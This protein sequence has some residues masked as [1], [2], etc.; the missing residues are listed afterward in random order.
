MWIRRAPSLLAFALQD[1]CPSIGPMY[2]PALKA[3]VFRLLKWFKLAHIH[4]HLRMCSLLGFIR[5]TCCVWYCVYQRLVIIISSIV[6]FMFILITGL[7]IG[8]G[9]L[10]ALARLF[11]SVNCKPPQ[12]FPNQCYSGRFF[13]SVTTVALHLSSCYYAAADHILEIA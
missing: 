9:I 6:R 4:I 2:P 5:L 7:E 10:I 1:R 11:P 12:L 3:I 13:A 8:P